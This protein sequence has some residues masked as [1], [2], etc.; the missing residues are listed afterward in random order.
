MV[1][2]KL[3]QMSE[4]V[5]WKE[6]AGYEGFYDISSTGLVR[7]SPNRKIVRFRDGVPY[8]YDK[9]QCTLKSM[10]R[11][12]GYYVVALWKNGVVKKH[13]V[14]RLFAEAF[15]PKESEERKFINHKDGNRGNNHPSN[16]EWCTHRENMQHAHDIGLNGGRGYKIKLTHI[17]TQA[18]FILSSMI[19]ASVFMGRDKGYLGELKRGRASAKN[20]DPDWG[21][22]F[23]KR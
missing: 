2:N 10:R 15:I 12:D 17:P 23:V 13:L 3:P 4:E 5:V 19:K 22:E 6:V 11:K 8:S 16:L 21:V 20:I 7:T 9:K 1:Q 14:H 18:T